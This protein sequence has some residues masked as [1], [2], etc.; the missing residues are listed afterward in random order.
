MRGLSIV[1]ED[2]AHI[3]IS[4]DWKVGVAFVAASEGSRQ[5]L[6]QN[7]GSIILFSLPSSGCIMSDQPVQTL[8]LSGASMECF[9]HFTMRSL[10]WQV[11]QLPYKP[12]NERIRQELR[13]ANGRS[14]HSDAGHPGEASSNEE[15][16][17]DNSGDVDFEMDPDLIAKYLENLQSLCDSVLE[18]KGYLLFFDKEDGFQLTWIMPSAWSHDSQDACAKPLE[19]LPNFTEHDEPDIIIEQASAWNERFNDWQTGVDIDCQESSGATRNLKVVFEA[20]LDVKKLLGEIL[21]AHS[22]ISVLNHDDDDLLPNDYFAFSLQGLGNGG[23]TADLVI[24]FKSHSRKN[25]GVL[26]VFVSLDLFTQNYKVLDW[27]QSPQAYNDKTSLRKMRDSLTLTRRMRQRRLGPF[28]VHP[29]SRGRRARQ[30][31]RQ[32][33]Q[34]VD[35]RSG[36]SDAADQDEAS[37]DEEEYGDNSVYDNF[38]Y[39][40]MCNEQYLFSGCDFEMDRDLDPAQWEPY[41]DMVECAMEILEKAEGGR[42]NFAGFHP[43][44][45]PFSSLYPDCELVTNRIISSGMPTQFLS[46]RKSPLKLVYC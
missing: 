19:L 7:I 42:V 40:H 18:H 30:R 20:Y 21:L 28:S 32:K 29:R 9:K 22:L 6:G 39:P 1:V 10:F 43:K 4:S 5:A 31:I 37:S 45:V 11:D 34:Q 17:G 8:T 46:G 12:R 23:R 26:G 13:Q 35:G 36:R 2:S 27:V 3:L 25:R 15:E 38:D 33:L 16:Y 41:C 14:G 44:V 24:V